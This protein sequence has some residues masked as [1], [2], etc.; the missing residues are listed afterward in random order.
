MVRAVCEQLQWLAALMFLYPANNSAYFDRV[1]KKKKDFANEYQEKHKGQC[2]LAERNYRNKLSPSRLMKAVDTIKRK[3][4]FCY[5]V[6]PPPLPPPGLSESWLLPSLLVGVGVLSGRIFS[7][8]LDE[9]EGKLQRVSRVELARLAEP[10]Q[11]LLFLFLPCSSA[12]VFLASKFELPALPAPPF[13]KM[14]KS[15]RTES[16]RWRRAPDI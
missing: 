14:R 11:T 1:K 9:S 4:L 16:R 3:S 13:S 6:P 7:L 15:T 2:W 5:P 8:C 10:D 12:L